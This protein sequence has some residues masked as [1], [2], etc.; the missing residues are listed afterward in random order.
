MF[1]DPQ[2]VTVNAVAKSLP[3][4]ERQNGTSVYKMDTG[5]YKLTISHQYGRRNRFNVRLDAQKIASDPLASA[6]NNLYSMSA[7]LVIDMPPV[8]YS[9]VEAKDIA[10]ALSAWATSANLLKVVG[11]ET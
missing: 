11:G 9:N 2:S 10:L 4:I 1:A 5:D 3:A 8:G 7:Y 6:N